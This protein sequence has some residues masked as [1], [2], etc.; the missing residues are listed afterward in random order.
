[1]K[2]EIKYKIYR[3]KN[4]IKLIAII[5]NGDYLV[6]NEGIPDDSWVIPKDVFESTYEEVV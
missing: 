5:E 6:Q 1:M 3:K 2:E 4:S